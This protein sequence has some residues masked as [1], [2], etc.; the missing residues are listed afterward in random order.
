MG[1]GFDIFTIENFHSMDFMRVRIC[2]IFEKKIMKQR[3]KKGMFMIVNQGIK[4]VIKIQ[5]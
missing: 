4:Q 3:L 2:T 1:A 5:N